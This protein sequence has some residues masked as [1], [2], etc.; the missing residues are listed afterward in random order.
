MVL[1]FIFADLQVYAWELPGVAGN[2]C[3]GLT[4]TVALQLAVVVYGAN[5]FSMLLEDLEGCKVCGRWSTSVER[6]T[7][8]DYGEETL[9]CNNRVKIVQEAGVDFIVFGRDG[10]VAAL[11][12]FFLKSLNGSGS[13]RSADGNAMTKRSKSGGVGAMVHSTEN[14]KK[15]EAV[16]MAQDPHQ[17]MHDKLLS[18]KWSHD[19]DIRN[20][21]EKLLHVGDVTGM[22]E[23]LLNAG[24]QWSIHGKLLHTGE[25]K[26]ELFTQ[27]K[28]CREMSQQQKSIELLQDEHCNEG[29][30]K[31]MDVAQK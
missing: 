11:R 10:F 31:G 14:K 15:Y 7:T 22:H 2:A 1:R 17:G 29:H 20:M 4:P 24:H 16:G 23:K 25:I 8:V 13:G 19:G 27:R 5:L 26:K 9:A 21:H 6:K 30:L 28:T 12:Q 18:K 3:N